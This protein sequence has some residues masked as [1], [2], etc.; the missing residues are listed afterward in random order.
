MEFIVR[1]GLALHAHGAHAL[2]VERALLALSRRFG[3]EGQFFA[4]PT[5][6]HVA[7]GALGEQ[8]VFLVRTEPGDQDLGKL[9]AL[10][11]LLVRTVGGLELGAARAELA[12]LAARPRRTPIALELLAYASTAAGAA[13]FLG[14]GLRDIPVAA[15]LGFIC[16]SAVRTLGTRAETRV[17][18]DA[19]AS[20]AVA[21]CATIAAS[22]LPGLAVGKLT[23]A[24][25]ISLLPGFSL[26]TAVNE[27]AT[28]HLASGTARFAGACAVFLA[29]GFGTALGWRLGF[30]TAGMPAPPNIVPAPDWAIVGA[31]ILTPAAFCVLLRVSRRDIG[32]VFL[33]CVVAWLGS[34]LGIWLLGPELSALAGAITVG[35]FSNGVARV[36]D[37][38]SSIPYVPGIL[39]LVPGSLGFASL[40][41]LLAEDVI[42]G[43]HT[44]FRMMLVAT[45][46]VAGVL[47]ANVLMP[48]RRVL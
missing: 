19:V 7:F 47:M 43:L 27:I 16:G 39:L 21:L 26:T 13:V 33:A 30:G 3:L 25:I 35:L 14:A 15:L 42:R 12:E 6:L 41:A 1:L 38:P 4:L 40:E 23:L 10:D 22:F 20:F 44:A 5:S 17:L 29:L 34:R 28:R 8:T 31:L 48:S 2:R 9:A 45:S 32:I 11:S 46:L 24:G 37:R 18:S 36:L